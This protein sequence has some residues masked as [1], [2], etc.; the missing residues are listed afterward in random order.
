MIFLEHFNGMYSGNSGKQVTA[1]AKL[2]EL[3]LKWPNEEFVVYEKG[4]SP[5]EFITAI[6]DKRGPNLLISSSA[7]LNEDLG[8]VEDTPFIKVNRKVIY[9]TWKKSAICFYIHSALIVKLIEAYNPTKNILYWL[10]SVAKAI[11]S[12]GVLCYQAPVFYSGEKLTVNDLYKFV[13]QHYKKRW[14]LILLFC[15]IIYEKRLPFIAFSKAIFYRYRNFNLD[16]DDIQCSSSILSSKYLDYDVIIPTLGRAKFLKQVL[17]DLSEQ[18]FL[19]KSVIIIEQNSESL[20]ET[21]LDFIYTQ[22]WPFQIDH[23]LIQSVGA[24][25]SRNIAISKS[26]ADWVLFFDDDLRVP[27]HFTQDVQK[28]LIRTQAKAV[29]FSCLQTNEIE[30]LENYKQWRTFGSGCSIVH[31]EI[32]K[33]CEFDLALEHGYGEDMDYGSQIRNAGY[34]V[35]YAPKIQLVHLKAPIG[36]FRSLRKFPWSEENISPKPSPQIMYNRSK[37]T[38]QYQLKGYK[39]TLFLKFYFQQDVKNPFTY[40][41]YFQKAW[42]SSLNWASKLP[43]NA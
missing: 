14:L 21:E 41:R 28:F 25:K 16:I 17:Q 7:N 42:S 37:N 29:T 32:V 43:I 5:D 11:Q 10:N 40:Y 31:K 22:S 12:K 38:T 8:Y 35:I 36:G 23:E 2:Y 30:Q 9:P 39:L 3:A 24:C 26:S 15:H 1:V 19:P 6:G 34:D 27:K 20:A 4:V 18:D 13:S 33:K